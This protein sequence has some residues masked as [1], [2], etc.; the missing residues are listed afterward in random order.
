MIETRLLRQFVVV[1][2]ELHFS[3]AAERLHM[4]QPPLSQAIKRL[5]E[6]IGYPLFI[7][8]KR[9]VELTSAGLALLDKAHEL[10]NTLDES[11]A[12][13]RR[14]AQGIAGHLVVAMI[15][16]NHHPEFWRALGVFREQMPAVEIRFVEATTSEQVALLESGEADVGFMRTPGTTVPSLTIERVLLDPIHLALPCNHRLAAASAVKLEALAGESFV[17]SSRALGQGFHDQILTLCKTAGVTPRI[18]QHARQI[19]TLLGLVAAGYGVA[20][21]PASFESVAMQGVS[22]RPLLH[23]A[24]PELG[25]VALNIASNCTVRSP[26]RDAFI[27]TIKRYL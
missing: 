13:T 10:L 7:R 20:L 24:P 21:V 4:A 15:N 3:R 18:A 23:E 8:D 2:E 14:V 5:E 27:D 25:C 9:S 1:A 12:Y 26:L 6:H 17:M 22:F 19:Q 16:L 11:V